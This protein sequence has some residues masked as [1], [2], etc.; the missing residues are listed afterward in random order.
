MKEHSAPK[1][2]LGFL[3][4]VVLVGA[5]YIF[6]GPNGVD[7]KYYSTVS[8]D[9][10][11]FYFYREF[12]AWYV[13]DT[14]NDFDQSGR[15]MAFLISAILFSLTFKTSEI[16]S[17]NIMISVLT[18]F[19]LTYSNF[20]LLLSVNGIRQGISLIFMLLSIYL[21]YKKNTYT[22]AIFFVFAI[23]S[24]NSTLLFLPLLLT[25]RIAWPVY[26]VGCI[27]LMFLGDFFIDYAFKN[28]NPS[29]TVNKVSFMAIS[30]FVFGIGIGH[31]LFKKYDGN[32]SGAG[33]IVLMSQFYLIAV[34]VA[35]FNSSSVYERIVYTSIPL[36]IIY[37]SF[38]L[39]FYR[40]K[41]VFMCIYSILIIVVSAYSLMHPS[42]RNNFFNL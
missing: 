16:F 31:K 26:I 2:K 20:Y 27:L 28:S 39:R 9:Y 3:I 6:M 29:P 17:E 10:S 18:S 36:L 30:L 25:K 1:R 14:I 12:V 35:F 37:S 40:P 8:P 13:V 34:G 4:T 33:R 32:V 22:W 23:F 38:W 15:L 5:S 24:H 19:L 11:E 21:Y 41:M 7:W 42:V